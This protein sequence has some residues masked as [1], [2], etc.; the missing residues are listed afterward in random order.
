MSPGYLAK[1]QASRDG[2]RRG[3]E[4]EARALRL[5]MENVPAWASGARKA[6]PNED[7]HKGWDVVIEAKDGC[8]VG[9]QVKSSKKK[10]REFLARRRITGKPFVPT[11]VVCDQRADHAIVYDLARQLR[12]GRP[13]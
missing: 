3:A 11:V 12:T 7:L 6:T 10:A 13:K 2:N 5:V 1:V 9:V 4:A 8:L